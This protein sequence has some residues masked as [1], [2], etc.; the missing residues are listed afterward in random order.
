MLKIKAFTGRL[1]GDM[2]LI[3]VMLFECVHKGRSVCVNEMK[4]VA[5]RVWFDC[6]IPYRN[7]RK[8]I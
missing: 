6:L 5:E 1:M 3:M 7:E 2:N 8:Q 4:C